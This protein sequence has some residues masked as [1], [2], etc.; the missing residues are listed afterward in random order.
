M[1]LRKK[2]ALVSRKMPMLR[3][4][5]CLACGGLM[6]VDEKLPDTTFIQCPLCGQNSWRVTQAVLAGVN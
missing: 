1:P 2:P 4:I 6:T 3:T 5:H